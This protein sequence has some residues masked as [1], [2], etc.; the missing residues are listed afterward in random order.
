M[1][2]LGPIKEVKIIKKLNNIISGES[3]EKLFVNLDHLTKNEKKNIKESSIEILK[4]CVPSTVDL[5]NKNNNF[6]NNTGL[7]IG[8]IQSGKTLSFTTVMALARDNGY[9]VVIVI[10]GRTNLLLKQTIDRLKI[11]LVKN[12]KFIKVL[13]NCEV[14][15]K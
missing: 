9:R 10:S 1:S 4:K 11:D 15:E 5:H 6:T 7:I 2:I 12:D 13:T 3:Y 8:K 14:P